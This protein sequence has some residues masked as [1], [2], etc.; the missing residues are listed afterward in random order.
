MGREVRRV[1]PNWEHP[2]KERF[3]YRLGQYVEDYQPLYDCDS[4]SAFK[5]WL[6]DW[7]DWC[8][9]RHDELREKYPEDHRECSQYACFCDWHATAPSPECYRPAWGAEDATWWQAYETVSEG[10][11]VSPPFATADELVEYLA[12][13]GDFWDQKRGAGPWNRASAEAFVKHDAYVPS[14]MVVDGQC[15]DGRDVP[16]L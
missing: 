4:D 16:S 15:I 3:D 9:F 8:S 5:E 11:P 1:I 2:K 10:T 13:H 12:T 7:N 14:M 6:S